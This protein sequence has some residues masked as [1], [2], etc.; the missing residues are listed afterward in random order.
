MLKG[1]GFGLTFR[2]SQLSVPI[3]V[4]NIIFCRFVIMFGGGCLR[5]YEHG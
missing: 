3:R 2:L 4:V 5:I 1:G